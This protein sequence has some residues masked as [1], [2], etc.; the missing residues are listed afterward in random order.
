M[1]KLS[2][3]TIQTKLLAEEEQRKIKYE[4]MKSTT[5][6]KS[7]PVGALTDPSTKITKIKQIV[8]PAGSEPKDNKGAQHMPDSEGANDIVDKFGRGIFKSTASGEKSPPTPSSKKGPKPNQKDSQTMVAKPTQ[9]NRGGKM[10][11]VPAGKDAR[12]VIDQIDRGIFKSG[13]GVTPQRA[14]PSY[15]K[16]DATTKVQPTKTV[17]AD[18]TRDPKVTVKD[19]TTGVLGAMPMPKDAPKTPSWASVKSGVI[20]EVQGRAKATLDIV[21]ESVLRR[22]VE[23]YEG[24]GYTVTLKRSSSIGWKKDKELFGLIRES[25]DAKHNDVFEHAKAHRLD[26]FKRFYE[27]VKKDQNGFYESDDEFLTLCRDA[28]KLVEAQVEAKY[29]AGLEV[30]QGIVRVQ[31][32]EGLEDVELISQATSPEMAARKIRS[33]IAEEYGMGVQIKHI[34]ID[35]TRVSAKVPAWAPS[36]VIAEKKELPD[37]IQKKIDAKKSKKPA[38][39]KEEKELDE[40][41][42]VTGMNTPSENPMRAEKPKSRTERFKEAQ[43]GLRPYGIGIKWDP[44][45]REFCVNYIGGREATAYYTDDLEDGIGTGK[46]MV[47]QPR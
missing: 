47:K 9:E 17:K 36:S 40:G 5:S 42:M 11:I 32:N 24:A 6:P 41:E 13:P 3:N 31:T 34:F 15:E 39:E 25:V 43:A 30:Y 12:D 45:T 8:V 27:V 14:T 21:S 2:V 46:Q 16:G 1:A 22:M 10:N 37:F 44:S 38:D 23:S 20:V 33:A 4:R 29:V 35:G 28:F 26:A 18:M 7:K 19:P